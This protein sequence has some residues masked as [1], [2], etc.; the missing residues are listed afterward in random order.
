MQRLTL[1]VNM[2]AKMTN[3]NHEFT[4][5]SICIHCGAPDEYTA[6]NSTSDR[7]A[8]LDRA[9]LDD[10][11]NKLFKTYEGSDPTSPSEAEF[12][13]ECEIL[14]IPGPIEL[15]PLFRSIRM[16]KHQ[17]DAST[18]LPRLSVGGR[19]EWDALMEQATEDLFGAAGLEAPIGP[20][21]V[22]W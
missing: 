20:Y 18:R 4:G 16:Q 15:G 9:Q 8:I 22:D 11:F 2:K 17:L 21:K 5:P 6:P 10:V 19:D 12:A 14:H 7:S 1:I 13:L 3:C